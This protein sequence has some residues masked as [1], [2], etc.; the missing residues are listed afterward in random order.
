MQYESGQ[1]YVPGGSLLAQLGRTSA[2][3]WSQYRAA[4]KRI[5][6]KKFAS[7]LDKQTAPEK[8]GFILHDYLGEPEYNPYEFSLDL[9]TI[10]FF[11]VPLVLILAG[12]IC[13]VIDPYDP[14]ET[15]YAD[16]TSDLRKNGTI[17][18][19]LGILAVLFLIVFYW[20]R[21]RS[22]DEYYSKNPVIGQPVYIYG[23]GNYPET[24]AAGL[25]NRQSQYYG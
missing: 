19:V 5:E 7:E 6:G 4:R 17:V 16:K 20:R 9:T 21:K 10:L 1:M 24:I 12:I 3:D 11:S 22:S 2:S 18:L 23:T 13:L 14:T 15:D 25:A 8:T